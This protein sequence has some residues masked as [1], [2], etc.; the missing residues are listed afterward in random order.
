[1]ECDSLKNITIPQSVTN[2]EGAALSFGTSTN[3]ATITM[4]STTPPNIQSNTFNTY[5]LDKS[6]FRKAQEILIKQ[7]QIGVHWHL[8]FRRQQNDYKRI[9]CNKK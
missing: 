5:R 9:L 2:I 4:L 8:I 3:K 1:M 6:S 7:Q